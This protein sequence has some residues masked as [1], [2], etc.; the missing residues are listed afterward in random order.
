[1]VGETVSPGVLCT[2]S[3]TSTGG[4]T[5]EAES[6]KR[7]VGEAIEHGLAEPCVRE[8]LGPLE[9]GQVGGDD[10]SGLLGSLGDDLE[11]RLSCHFGQRNVAEFIDDVG[12]S[13]R[14]FRRSPL[15]GRQADHLC[16]RDTLSA[17]LRAAAFPTR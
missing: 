12:C 4:S 7:L 13:S 10:D 14:G 11:E 17:A 3:R 8:D 1:M 6:A 9:E 15:A 16:K 5:P 2:R